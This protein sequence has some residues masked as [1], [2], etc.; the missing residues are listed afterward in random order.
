MVIWM[1]FTSITKLWSLCKLDLVIQKYCFL[2]EG[3]RGSMTM[4]SNFTRCRQDPIIVCVCVQPSGSFQNSPVT[5]NRTLHLIIA[6]HASPS[7]SLISPRVIRTTFTCLRPRSYELNVVYLM[8]ERSTIT[9]DRIRSP[10]RARPMKSPLASFRS[11]VRSSNRG[12]QA[13]V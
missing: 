12:L 13:T 9:I 8:W 4:I 2:F 6:A 11:L 1:K 7:L 5:S 10:G 3:E